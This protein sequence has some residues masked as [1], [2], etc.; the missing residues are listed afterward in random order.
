MTFPARRVR[1][2]RLK[3][4]SDALVR[5]GAI[6]LEDALRTASLPE[7]HAG[8]LLIFRSLDVGHIHT[9]R[10]PSS[11]ALSIERRVREIARLAVHAEDPTAAGAA[12][13]YFH[14]DA[15]PFV[16]LAH[17]LACGEAAATWF[18]PLAVPGFDPHL[19]RDDS[20]RLLLLGALRSTAGAAA[21]LRLVESLGERQIVAPLLQALRPVDGPALLEA[22]GWP[23][24]RLPTGCA[25]PARPSELQA[26]YRMP[27]GSAVANWAP[28]WGEDDPRSIWL[29][30]MALAA[31]SPGRLSVGN[32]VR[33]GQ[34]ILAALKEK[35]LAATQPAGREQAALPPMEPSLHAPERHDVPLPG[36]PDRRGDD[37]PPEHE[38]AVSAPVSHPREKDAVHAPDQAGL[39]PQHEHSPKA[40]PVEIAAVEPRSAAAPHRRTHLPSPLPAGGWP[41]SIGGLFF[42]LP[43]LERLGFVEF[44]D[45]HEELVE[46]GLPDRIL[47]HIARRLGAPEN[48]PLLASLHLELPIGIRKNYPFTSPDRF[49]AIAGKPGPLVFASSS[50]MPPRVIV[51]DASQRLPLAVLHGGGTPENPSWI[52]AQRSTR[53]SENRAGETDLDVLLRSLLVAVRRFARQRVRIGLANLVRRPG[54]FISTPTHLDILFEHGQVDIRLRRA[55]I[56]IDPGWVP[57]LGR[58]VRFHYL[59]GERDE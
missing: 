43:I 3:A 12:A 50:E 55:G 19:P 49:H 11:L 14:D 51:Y 53:V 7:S 17:R 18:W 5:R 6:L 34:Q 57:W 23:R 22:Y 36:R 4:E 54:R 26:F 9:D 32:L 59:Y 13:V 58:V 29:A 27:L 20:L 42:L 10:A 21:A 40:R 15:E 2:V 56:D 41:T 39:P 52:N 8:R 37:M 38:S 45:R 35:P 25:E 48:D 1:T 30:A 28:F 24:P 47:D 44:L 46:I 31:G 33:R 16:T